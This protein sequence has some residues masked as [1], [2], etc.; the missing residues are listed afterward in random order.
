MAQVIEA[1]SAMTS[2]NPK[3]YP[4][5][6]FEYWIRIFLASCLFRK[7][8]EKHP[9]NLENPEFKKYC[10]F[11][12][13]E[14]NLILSLWLCYVLKVFHLFNRTI[15]VTMVDFKASVPL[16]LVRTVNARKKKSNRSWNSL[17]PS[18]LISCTFLVLVSE[19]NH[20]FCISISLPNLFLKL[21]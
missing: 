15:E 16:F 6:R 4:Q 9:E 3:F 17:S 13:F 5:E 11:H 10:R 21:W 12:Q 1:L 7:I 14:V 2:E 19:R 20:E 8:L 18:F